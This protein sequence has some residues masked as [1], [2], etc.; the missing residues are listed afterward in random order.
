M[1]AA[2]R[3]IRYLRGKLELKITYSGQTVVVVVVQKEHQFSSQLLLGTHNSSSKRQR[4]INADQINH[5]SRAGGAIHFGSD[6]QRIT[7]QSTSESELIAMNTTAKHGVYFA[8]M[9]GEL[10]RGKL[11]TFR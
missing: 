2:R 11:R 9:K 6:F 1:G 4:Q 8:F 5:F 7:V 3:I 10:G